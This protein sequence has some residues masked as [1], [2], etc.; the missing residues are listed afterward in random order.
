MKHKKGKVN[1][2][3]HR[4]LNDLIAVLDTANTLKQSYTWGTD[5]SGSK[6]GA[7]GV[8]GL[9]WIYDSSTSARYF[10][11]YDGNGNVSGL[12][13]STDG[14]VSAQ[15]DYGP[16][17]EVIRQ[18]GTMATNNPFRFSTKFADNETDLLYYGYRYYN[19]STGRWLSKDPIEEKG[20]LNL[21]DFSAN[22]G[23]NHCDYFGW[24]WNF[25]IN[26]TGYHDPI[27]GVSW[28]GRKYFTTGLT[29]LTKWQ[30]SVRLVPCPC[31]YKLRSDGD[32]AADFWWSTPQAIF[33]ELHHAILW[34]SGFTDTEWFAFQ[35]ELGCYSRAKA[36]CY[37]RAVLA[38]S[39]YYAARASRENAEYDM[40]EY[41]G[42]DDLCDRTYK[43]ENAK[44][45][46]DQILAQCASIQ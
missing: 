26:D 14:T 32:G 36:Q 8:G 15:Y 44:W 18:T 17:G 3:T 40:A 24:T 10:A 13:K 4:P 34:E 28:N 31:G 19:P 33:H 45:N 25:K 16:F 11:S 23:V 5:L 42:G 12:V 21:Y 39:A 41:G 1:E 38:A 7:G 20:G 37:Q 43:E 35:Y 29:T 30:V 27:P 9:L 46:L 6:Q 22:D 2:V